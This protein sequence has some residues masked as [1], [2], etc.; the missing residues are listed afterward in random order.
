MGEQVGR[1]VVNRDRSL[2][3]LVAPPAAAQS[4]GRH[5]GARGGLDVVGRIADED[6]L[7]ATSRFLS[8]A[9]TA[10][11]AVLTAPGSSAAVAGSTASTTA[12]TRSRRAGPTWR[13]RSDGRLAQAV[14]RVTGARVGAAKNLR[15]GETPGSG[16]ARS[17]FDMIATA[18][19][20][21]AH[22]GQARTRS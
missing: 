5:T 20:V 11:D 13:C 15:S 1:I 6:G 18:A 8:A 3:I 16:S 17:G 21:G 9:S 2:E 10:P 7:A 19:H 4:D 14:E 12:S 22:P